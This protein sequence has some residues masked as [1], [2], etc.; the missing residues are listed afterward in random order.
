MLL[1]HRRDRVDLGPLDIPAL[2]HLTTNREAASS[3]PDVK[4]A[5]TES[6]LAGDAKERAY[7]VYFP[8]SNNA[9][10]GLGVW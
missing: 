8:P 3:A 2:H 1:I 10:D 9:R 4:S 6:T 5:V 7:D